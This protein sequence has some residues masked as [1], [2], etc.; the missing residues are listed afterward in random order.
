VQNGAQAITELS[1]RAAEYDIVLLDLHMPEMDGLQALERIRR[2]DA[3]ARARTMWII[4][5]TA[6]VR[7]E[8]RAKGFA[9]GL[10]DYLTKPLRVPELDAAFRRFRAERQSRKG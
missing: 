4:A 9:T 3:G 8:Q 6:D 5:L 2:G 10:N 7:P 1:E